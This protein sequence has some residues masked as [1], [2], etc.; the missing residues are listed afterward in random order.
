MVKL[1]VS[2]C[3]IQF[4]CAQ[5]NT[6]KVGLFLTFQIGKRKAQTTCFWRQSCTQSI[7]HLECYWKWAWKQ[8]CT[9]MPTTIWNQAWHGK[10]SLKIN[11]YCSTIYHSI[12]TPPLEPQV[13]YYIGGERALIELLNQEILC[14]LYSSKD[15]KRL[16]K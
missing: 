12:L 10:I 11:W 1:T 3:K 9:L 6:R 16:H 5:F 4:S 8:S 13:H 15:F 7:N 14:K 2:Q